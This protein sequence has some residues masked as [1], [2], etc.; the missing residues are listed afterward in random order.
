MQLD[1]KGTKDYMAIVV[2]KKQLDFKT[3]NELANKNTGTSYEEMLKSALPEVLLT[4]VKF[5]DGEA[6]GISETEAEDKA[7]LMVI[8]I[9]KK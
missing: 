7:V 8:E 9:N 1:D 5:M 6:I 3:V 2:S 4:N